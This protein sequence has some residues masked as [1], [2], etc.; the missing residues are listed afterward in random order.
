M[1]ARKGLL[2]AGAL[3]FLAATAPAQQFNGGIPAGWLCTGT[4][5]TLGA[6]GVVTL[7]PG[8][9]TQYGFVT[10]EGGV[11]GAN[12]PGVG[13]T[14]SPAN[15]SKLLSTGFAANAGDALTFDFNY[16]TSDG[17]GFADYAWAQL[18]DASMNPVAILFTARTAPSGSIVPGFSMPAPA[19]TLTPSSVPIIGSCT[20]SFGGCATTQWSPLG[21]SGGNGGSTDCFDVGCGFTNWILAT[22]SIAAAGTYFLEFGVTNW[23]DTQFDSGL[24]F[25]G[26]ALNDAPI[27]GGGG[28]PTVTPEPATLFL[29]GTGL[30]GVA[31]I[32]RRRRKRESDAA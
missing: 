8:G 3:V 32:A 29:V 28:G 21:P 25:D 26:L 5:G 12:L 4:C 17:A 24:A 1:T 18:L 19:A 11:D 7:A 27:G 15:G 22:Y 10:T 16:V 9:G 20:F 23:N 14:G 6:N 31:G 30:I 2:A 13:G